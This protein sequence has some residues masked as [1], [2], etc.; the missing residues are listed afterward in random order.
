MENTDKL[1]DTVFLYRRMKDRGLATGKMWVHREEKKGRLKLRVNP[2]GWRKVTELDIKEI[3]K[4]Y[5]PGGTGR[6]AYHE[7]SFQN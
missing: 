4:A 1:F 6:W 5:S 7:N 3:I 2:K